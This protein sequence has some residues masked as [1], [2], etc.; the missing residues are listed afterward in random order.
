[1]QR[2]QVHGCVRGRRHAAATDQ[3]VRLN[4]HV[5]ACARVLMRVRRG[6]PGDVSQDG[7]TPQEEKQWFIHLQHIYRY[8]L[9]GLQLFLPPSV[10]V[11]GFMNH[12]EIGSG[13][14]VWN[15]SGLDLSE[16]GV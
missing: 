6:F 2:V 8:L 12:C 11:M 16:R 5:R 1:M 7:Q 4:L 13:V 9:T 10:Q 3:H 14:H 15:D